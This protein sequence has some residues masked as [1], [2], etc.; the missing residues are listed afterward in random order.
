V[1]SLQAVDLGLWEQASARVTEMDGAMFWADVVGINGVQA[2]D[3]RLFC[4]LEWG[5]M[6]VH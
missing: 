5:G 3:H 4:V 6:E 1:S 2:V